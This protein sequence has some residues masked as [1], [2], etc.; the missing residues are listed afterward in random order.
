MVCGGACFDADAGNDVWV[1][2]VRNQVVAAEYVHL[3]AITTEVG[4]AR[5]HCRRFG[6]RAE[7]AKIAG[8]R[9]HGD[10]HGDDDKRD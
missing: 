6:R 1:C 8:Q 9:H 2:I 3:A 4:G 5:C 10:G 7:C